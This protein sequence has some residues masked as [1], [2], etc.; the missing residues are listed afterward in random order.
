MV[1]RQK[2]HVG[3][4]QQK[5]QKQKEALYVSTEIDGTDQNLVSKGLEVPTPSSF[6][7]LTAKQAK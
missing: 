5:Q 4:Q 1:W 6:C 2:R 7:F 3:Q